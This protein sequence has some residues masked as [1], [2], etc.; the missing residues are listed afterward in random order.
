MPESFEKYF[1]QKPERSSEFHKEREISWD[2]KK[3]ITEKDWEQM[4]TLVEDYRKSGDWGNL[5]LLAMNMKILDP[6]KTVPLTNKEWEIIRND[7]EEY[8]E[9][10]NWPG[11]LLKGM[12]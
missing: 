3:E 8:R 1:P 11:V 12:E 7:L 10:D 2:S 4:R 9:S 5:F 6:E